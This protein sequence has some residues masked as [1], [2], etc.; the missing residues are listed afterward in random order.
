[1]I[2][3][4]DKE[5]NELRELVRMASAG[6][7]RGYAWNQ[8][9]APELGREWREHFN[10]KEE[11]DLARWFQGRRADAVV[12]DLTAARDLLPK[13]ADARAEVSKLRGLLKQ[14]LEEVCAQRDRFRALLLQFEDHVLGE[15]GACLICQAPWDFKEQKVIHAPDCELAEAVK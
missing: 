12:Y 10:S 4:S 7:A 1:M 11:A 6:A 8:P 5:L 15:S 3:L 13:L 9:P 2:A 14:A